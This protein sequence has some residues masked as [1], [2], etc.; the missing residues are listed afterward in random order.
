M[1]TKKT[2]VAGWGNFPCN[3]AFLHRPEKYNHIK[4]IKEVFIPRGLGRSYGDA[5]L[6]SEGHIVLMERLNRFLAFDA[7]SGVLRLEAGCSLK[8]ILAV[9]VP[10]GWFLPVTPGTQHVTIGGCIAADVHGKNHHRDGSIGAYVEELEVV[11]GSGEKRRCS[12]QCNEDL[13]M[14]T[15]GGMGLTGIITEATLRLIPIE[16]AYMSVTHHVAQN[17]EKALELLDDASIDDHYS[18]AWIDCLA[19]GANFGRSILMQGRHMRRDELVST[20][21]DDPL[22]IP[23]H[24]RHSIPFN[25][26]SWILNPW[27]VRAFNAI[28]WSA[29]KDKGTF[30]TDYESYFYPLDAI[31]NWNRIYGKKGFLQYQCV[32][33]KMGGEI[34]LREI[35]GALA[36][37]QRG[38][39]LAVLKRFGKAGE[40]Y[41]SFPRE[42]YT[43]ALDLPI[44]DEGLFSLLDRLDEMVVKAGGAVYLAKDA[45]MSAETFRAMYPKFGAWKAVKE[46]YDLT[47]RFRSDLSRRLRM[48]VK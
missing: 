38:S 43:L 27:T 24:S 4:A 16:T 11:I 22:K 28:Y 18:V 7:V 12:R 33:P 14:A 3:A 6:N 23:S 32:V 35:L 47:W 44:R 26:P 29:Q 19:T 42:G 8:E 10:K 46:K 15:L 5:A 48:E 13:F 17:L 31:K 36:G 25:L 34:A 30:T 37:S 9:I 45:R 1:A 2:Q 20:K 41:L 21:I 40:G 39:F